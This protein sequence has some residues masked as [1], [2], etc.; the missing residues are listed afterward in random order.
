MLDK[1]LIQLILNIASDC[2][3]NYSPLV[4]FLTLYTI[5]NVQIKIIK[6][7]KKNKTSDRYCLLVLEDENLKSYINENLNVI[8]IRAADLVI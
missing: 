8:L 3:E 5:P 7:I 6:K 1:H 4:L 2:K